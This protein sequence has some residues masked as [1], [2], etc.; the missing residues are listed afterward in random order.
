YRRQ[1]TPDSSEE[2]PDEVRIALAHTGESMRGALTLFFELDARLSRLVSASSEP[3]LGQVRMAWWRDTLILPAN[4]RPGGDP[5]LDGIG[6]HM[7]G[8]EG[9]F[10]ALVN[11][12]EQMLSEPPL[13]REAAS[14]FALGRA[15]GLVGLAAHHGFG[16]DVQEDVRAAGFL[17]AL[18]DA[19][20]HISDRDE[21]QTLLNLAQ[22]QQPP[23]RLPKPFR[24]LAVLAALSLRA[25]NAGGAPLMAGRAA[26][27]V[28]FRAALLGR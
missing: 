14:D 20:S 1:M 19:V 15:D 23:G 2:L 5:I 22:E 10:I 26:G 27:L 4:E 24:G 8:A 6:A 16:G 17:W 7:A 11:G 21:R 9:A 25:I 18:A 12:W 13:S 3:L 28:A